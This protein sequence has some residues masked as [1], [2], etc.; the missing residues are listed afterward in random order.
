MQPAYC[1]FSKHCKVINCLNCTWVHLPSPPLPSPR[2]PHLRDLYLIDLWG[3]KSV[4]Y[5]VL[6][7]FIKSNVPAC[8][9]WT[10]CFVDTSTAESIQSQASTGCCCM[11][12]IQKLSTATCIDPTRD[13]LSYCWTIYMLL[14]TESLCT[15]Q[16]LWFTCIPVCF[17]SQEHI[18]D[19]SG[20]TC[21][22]F[23]V[24]WQLRL[25]T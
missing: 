9:W 6:W 20:E 11:L 12:Q 13:L 24:S 2:A 10:V 22:T 21:N 25:V 8:Y 14:N 5:G 3:L 15:S 16:W 19:V 4:V 1:D 18:I 7:V 23:I 17:C